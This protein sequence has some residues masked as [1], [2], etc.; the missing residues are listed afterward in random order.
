MVEALAVR[1]TCR[2]SRPELVASTTLSADA[3]GGGRADR[4]ALARAVDPAPVTAAMGTPFFPPL[5]YSA[6]RV[7]YAP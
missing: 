2:P 3:V 6:F 5:N 1:R 4:N 7:E